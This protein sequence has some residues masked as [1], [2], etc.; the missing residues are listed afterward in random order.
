MAS[1]PASATG[2]PSTASDMGPTLAVSEARL[3]APAHRDL[4]RETLN[5][6]NELAGGSKAAQRQRHGIGDAYDPASGP[7]GCLEQVAVVQVSALSGEGL[8]WREAKGSAT[9]GIEQG[10]EDA[11]GVKIGKAKPVDRPV[12]ST[13]AAV[14]PRRSP[15]N[16]ESGHSRFAELRAVSAMA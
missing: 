14:R 3:D 10:P 8:G 12:A 2:T 6:A 13:R 7:K 1:A 5:R 11:A 15:R 9:L 16:R 4:T